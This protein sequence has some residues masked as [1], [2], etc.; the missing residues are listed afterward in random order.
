MKINVRTPVIL[1]VALL[2]ALFV[3]GSVASASVQPVGMVIFSITRRQGISVG[4]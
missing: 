2:V 1:A 3:A 4:L